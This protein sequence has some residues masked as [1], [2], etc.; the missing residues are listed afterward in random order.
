MWHFV[1]VYGILCVCVA[2]CVL[3]DPVCVTGNTLLKQKRSTFVMTV[4]LN[5]QMKPFVCISGVLLV[6]ISTQNFI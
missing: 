4:C 2:F 3:L 5:L 6:Q 1:C